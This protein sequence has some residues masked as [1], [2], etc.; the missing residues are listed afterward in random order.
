METSI[1][2][3]VG[4]LDQIWVKFEYQGHWVKV[5]VTLVNGLFVGHHFFSMVPFC[6]INVV[7]KVNLSQGQGH[8]RIKFCLEVGDGL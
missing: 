4:H 1:F 2:G 8:F 5:K 3:I 6:A 7:I